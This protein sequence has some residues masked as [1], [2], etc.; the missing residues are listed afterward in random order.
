MLK[1]PN[2]IKVYECHPD[3]SLDAYK[4]VRQKLNIAPNKLQSY[5]MQ[6]FVAN[7]FMLFKEES[8]S[9]WGRRFITQ[10]PYIVEDIAGFQQV[11]YEIVRVKPYLLNWKILHLED[12]PSPK[13]C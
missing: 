9:Y 8:G 3:E 4:W 7:V 13:S 1:H 11:V 2:L 10:A 5:S 12:A 6:Q